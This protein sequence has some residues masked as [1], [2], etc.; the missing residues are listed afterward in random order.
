MLDSF[1]GPVYCRVWDPTYEP[2][3]AES[4]SLELRSYVLIIS[5]SHCFSSIWRTSGSMLPWSFDGWGFSGTKSTCEGEGSMSWL[6]RVWVAK[7]I[8]QPD[9]PRLHNDIYIPQAMSIL[10]Q[11]ENQPPARPLMWVT[12]H[13]Q[14][15]FIKVIWNFPVW[16]PPLY[17]YN[18]T[19]LHRKKQWATSG[20]WKSE[21]R[22]IAGL[23]VKTDA[24][25]GWRQSRLRSMPSCSIL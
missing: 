7:Y 13:M 8:H 25:I 12:V 21:K 10:I 9:W 22:I 18:D 15:K 14:Y 1:V 24:G 17:I 23:L 20:A 19:Y 6:Q 3:K 2:W 5:I 16:A 11:H 4:E